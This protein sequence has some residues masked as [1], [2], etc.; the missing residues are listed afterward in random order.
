MFPGLQ[1][2]SK[3]LCNRSK[4]CNTVNRAQFCPARIR[5]LLTFFHDNFA[6]CLLSL[7]YRSGTFSTGQCSARCLGIVWR[8][9]PLDHT[10]CTAS[11]GRYRPKVQFYQKRRKTAQIWQN[12]KRFLQECASVASWWNS[13]RKRLSS[14][15]WWNI[16]SGGSMSDSQY[17]KLC[18]EQF[19][20]HISSLLCDSLAKLAENGAHWS[21]GYGKQNDQIWAIIKKTDFH[22]T[23]QYR[24]Q[25]V[26]LS[27]NLS[28][29]FRAFWMRWFWVS[30]SNTF[31][32]STSHGCVAIFRSAFRAFS[33]K[34]SFLRVNFFRS[35]SV[36]ITTILACSRNMAR[37]KKNSNSFRALETESEVAKII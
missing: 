8:V 32:E 33:D 25:V 14:V 1:N 37:L 27:T 21:Y 6:A 23:F 7:G 34:K 5:T 2:F 3:K 15:V 19:L 18:L 28:Y 36:K 12:E 13:L 16:Q 30:R 24:P 11:H 22:V 17:N 10:P 9:F 4:C 31:H 20:T 26:N 29:V 35:F